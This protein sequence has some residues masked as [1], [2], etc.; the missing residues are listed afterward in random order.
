MTVGD[1]V[2]WT[3]RDNAIMHTATSGT[4]GTSDGGWD[5]GFMSTNETF[6]HTFAAAGTFPYTCIIHPFMNATMT[7]TE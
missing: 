7:V 6:S 3:N 2:V 1:T 4:N 5:S